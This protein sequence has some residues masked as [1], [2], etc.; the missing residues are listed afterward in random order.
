MDKEVSTL[1]PEKPVRA[2]KP[3]RSFVSV[4]FLTF[5]V[6]LAYVIGVERGRSGSSGVSGMLPSSPLFSA[7]DSNRPDM[8]T[9]WKTWDL[10][11]ERFVD[12]EALDE[13]KLFYGAIDGMLSATDDP[14][15][16]FFDP[17]ENKSFEEDLSGSFEGI[18]AEIGMK[19]KILTV[20]APLED[21]PAERAGLRAGDTI[22]KI[23]DESTESMNV[24]VA[25]KKMRGKK[26]T[27][28][29][30]SIFREGEKE[31]RDIV[32]RRD[33]IIVK[34]VKFDWKENDVALLKINQFGDETVTEVKGVVESFQ[35]RVPKGLIIDLRNNPGGRLDATVDIGSFFL[36]KGE[37]VTIE[38]DG[39]GNRE[40]LRTY[41]V[42][43]G[44]FLRSVPTVVLINEGSASASEILAAALRE[45]RGDVTLVGKKSFG[46]G[47]VQELVGVTR[48]TSLKVTVA[49]WLTPSGKQINK[50]GIVPDV[51]VE[52][53]DE[54]YESDR[55]PQLDRAIE[56]LREKL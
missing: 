20:V 37:T 27:E 7:D 30:L 44:A 53:T 31:T 3:R 21:A 11:H 23:N 29:K 47:S 55:D 6:V 14:Y 41:E 40:T 39:K 36:S 18:G 45:N 16:T 1:L 33:T 10:L 2:K 9:F 24:D 38:E 35:S 25:V 22:I 50:E 48:E 49:R 54:D 15:T 32:I 17:E 8:N 56:I 28:V 19:N 12:R 34:S 51:E 42:K 5:A 46:K 13:T 52:L 26:G 43:N 4:F